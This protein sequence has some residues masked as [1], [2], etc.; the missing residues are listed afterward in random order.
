MRNRWQ[1]TMS[2]VLAAWRGER[3]F[4]TVT[5]MGVLLVGGLLVAAAFAAVVPDIRASGNDL[6]RKKAWAAAEAGVAYYS[7]RLAVDPSFWTKCDNVPPPSP[8]DVNPVNQPWNGT[9][10]DPRRWRTIPGDTAQYTIELLPAPGR[11]TCDPSDPIGSMIDT[12]SGT[13]RV[14]VTG[15]AR[16]PRTSSDR[17]VKRSIIVRFKRRSFLN[18]IYFTDFETRDPAVY[19][20]SQTQAQASAQ[21]QRY[22]RNGRPLGD[23]DTPCTPIYFITGDNVRGPMHTNDGIYVC[24]NPVF[25]RNANDPVEISEPAPGWQTGNCSGSPVWQGAYQPGAPVLD[26]P[27]TNGQLKQQTDQTYLFQGRTVITLNGASMTVD[28]PAKCSS[29]GLSNPCTMSLPSNGLIYVDRASGGCPTPYDQRRQYQSATS[30]GE[31]WVRGTYSRPLTIGAADDIVING[32]IQRSGDVLLGLIANEFV[33]VYHP[34]TS[35]GAN[36]SGSLSNPTIDAA[37][38][39]LSHSFLV[40]NYDEGSPLGTL[41]VTGVIAQRFRGPVGTFSNGSPVTGYAKNYTYDDRLRFRSPPYFLDPVRA[42]WKVVEQHEQVP[43]R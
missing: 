19:S 36:A 26:M 31:A 25:G 30:C 35:S 43:A 38:L 21:C 4:T 27:P 18:F 2:A 10:S 28:N 22:R 32:N 41:T 34:V 14:R 3:G 20:G 7:Y 9:G 13:F 17:P 33:R 40:D 37:I 29:L 5:L 39:A 6:Q 42:G 11:S 23:N 24:G 16:A 15:R 8:G 1:R 12:A